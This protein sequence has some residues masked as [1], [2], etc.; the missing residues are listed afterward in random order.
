MQAVTNQVTTPFIQNKN[1]LTAVKP[2]AFVLDN[3]K[4]FCEHSSAAFLWFYLV[5][6]ETVP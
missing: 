6:V 3:I 1:S 2:Q 4:P 5:F